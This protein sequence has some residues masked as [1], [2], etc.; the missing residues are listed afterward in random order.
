MKKTLLILTCFLFSITSFACVS[1]SDPKGDFV[2]A[3][4]EIKR[5]ANGNKLYSMVWNEVKQEAVFK[6][7]MNWLNFD[8]RLHAG[9]FNLSSGSLPHLLSPEVGGNCRLRKVS[10]LIKGKLNLAHNTL[11]F[12]LI[13][14]DCFELLEHFK[15]KWL[16]MSWYNMQSYDGCEKTQVFRIY[17]MDVPQ[18]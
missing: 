15:V 12:K 6:I 5:D 14:S 7:Q 10:G 17:L 9:G 1:T 4:M 16:T 18:N 2:E 13:G 3:Q 8:D 11:K